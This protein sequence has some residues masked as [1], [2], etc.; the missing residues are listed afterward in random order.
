MDKKLS[1]VIPVFNEQEV[2]PESF[3][4][5]KAAMDAM[6]YPYEIIYIDDGSRDEH[7]RYCPK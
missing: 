6:G 2:M 3:R 4:R 1:L 7:G 5:T